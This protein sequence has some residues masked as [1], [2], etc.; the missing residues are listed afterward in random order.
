MTRFIIIAII[1]LSL[2][3]LSAIAGLFGDN[4]ADQQAK[5]ERFIDLGL[6]KYGKTDA[7]GSREILVLTKDNTGV[8]THQHLTE[9]DGKDFEK[10]LENRGLLKMM[11]NKETGK[12]EKHIMVFNPKDKDTYVWVP[13]SKL[14]ETLEKIKA[15]G[16]TLPSSADPKRTTEN[17]LKE[18][19]FNTSF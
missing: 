13:V 3:P 18:L 1:I 11:P 8:F 10:I 5:I 9:A 4:T 12:Q 16:K 6:I 15:T 17:D 14:K 19:N 2:Q 7:S